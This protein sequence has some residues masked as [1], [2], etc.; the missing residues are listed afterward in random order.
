MKDFFSKCDQ[1]TYFPVIFNKL[2]IFSLIEISSV[3]ADFWGVESSN[4]C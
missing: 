3:S 1:I 2:N 4:F